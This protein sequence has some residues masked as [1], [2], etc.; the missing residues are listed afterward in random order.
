MSPST[1]L[2]MTTGPRPLSSS[3]CFLFS[4]AL[5]GVSL[6]GCGPRPKSAEMVSY[7]RLKMDQVRLQNLQKQCPDLIAESLK[8]YELARD[9]GD[10]KLSQHYIKLAQITWQTAEMRAL[11][12]EHRAK[13]SAVQS[14]RDAAQQLLN[15][16]IARRKELSS[17]K[18]RQARLLEQ[19]AIE[20]QQSQQASQQEQAKLVEDHL[21]EARRLRDQANQLRAPELVPGPYKRAEMALRSAEATVQRQDLS[22][23]ARI[24]QGA[25]RDFKQAI[26]AAK[27]LFEKYQRKAELEERMQKLLRESSQVR[28]AEAMIEMRGVVVTLKGLY[29]KHKLTSRG[30]AILTEIAPVIARYSD[31]RVMIIGHTTSY[32]KRQAK[33]DRSEKMATQAR[34]VLLSQMTSQMQFN[35]VGR[36]DY[37]P[38]SS[39]SRSAQNDRIEIVFFKPRIK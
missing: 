36:G 37:V 26:A 15:S 10:E 12:M 3:I 1:P 21:R 32:G 30:R 11:H 5:A 27:P 2:D 25:Q 22:N 19:R 34:D 8:Q 18:T 14:R 35:V 24:A 31:L 4:L 39:N 13:M 6:V 20:Q 38:I 23:A 16:A 17:L 7:E 33:I 28:G 9:E 29:R